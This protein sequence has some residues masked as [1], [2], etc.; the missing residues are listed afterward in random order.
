MCYSQADRRSCCSC[1]RL[2]LAV[3][4]TV[5]CQRT[6]FPSTF[7]ATFIFCCYMIQFAD[8]HFKM[9]EEKSLLHVKM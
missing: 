4:C 3:V 2:L 5:V 1:R 7:I 6:E 8:F 9:L